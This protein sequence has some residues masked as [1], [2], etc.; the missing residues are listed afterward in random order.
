MYANTFTVCA[1][2]YKLVTKAIAKY[3]LVMNA[4]CQYLNYAVPVFEQQ[5]G[6]VLARQFYVSASSSGM[7]GLIYH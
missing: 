3:N 7:K 1:T 4:N 2:T 5:L 6:R